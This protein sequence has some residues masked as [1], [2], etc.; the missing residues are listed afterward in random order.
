M[1]ENIKPIETINKYRYT[2][3]FNFISDTLEINRI[4][5]NKAIKSNDNAITTIRPT[6]ILVEI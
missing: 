4:G 2:S 5:F 3:S 1:K 6:M